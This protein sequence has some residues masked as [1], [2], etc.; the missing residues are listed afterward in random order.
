M[1]NGQIF[2][3]AYLLFIPLTTN[4]PISGC[5]IMQATSNTQAKLFDMQISISIKGA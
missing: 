4:Y 5:L 3:K 1:P 2:N